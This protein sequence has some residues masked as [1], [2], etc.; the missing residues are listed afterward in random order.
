MFS[1]LQIKVG[2]IKKIKIE[3]YFCLIKTKNSAPNKR[4]V[5]FQKIKLKLKSCLAIFSVVASRR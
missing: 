2:E 3:V 4:R 1:Y 5:F